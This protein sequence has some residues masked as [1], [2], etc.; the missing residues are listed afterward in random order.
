MEEPAP[1]SQAPTS[2]YYNYYSYE[3]S[4]KNI[5]KLLKRSFAKVPSDFG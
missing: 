4:E 3:E 1:Y 2:P 5:R